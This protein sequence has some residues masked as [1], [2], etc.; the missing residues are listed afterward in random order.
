MSQTHGKDQQLIHE[1][2]GEVED[3]AI[4]RRKSICKSEDEMLVNI[5]D[6]RRCNRGGK[7][8]A[9]NSRHHHM[10]PVTLWDIPVN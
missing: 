9:M 5:D 2:Y 3:H 6:W 4:K 1:D 8:I 10:L 7:D